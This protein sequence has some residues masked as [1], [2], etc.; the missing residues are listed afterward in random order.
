MMR[1]GVWAWLALTLLVVQA[2][3]TARGQVT[4]ADPD[5]AARAAIRD[6]VMRI[7]DTPTGLAQVEQRCP[8]LP[9]ALQTAGIRSLIIASSRER[10]DRNSL[11]GLQALLHP[12]PGAGPEVATLEPIL[13]ELRPPVA[14]TR[15]WWQRLWDWIV[16]RFTGKEPPPTDAWLSEIVRQMINARWLWISLI[17]CLL[18]AVVIA[19][20][21]V[22]VREARVRRER[23]DQPVAAPRPGAVPGPADSR[24]ALLRRAPLEQR[25][26]QLFA[27]LISRL[28]SAGRLPAD[29]SLT[30]REVVRR[31]QLDDPEQRRFIDSLARLSERQIYSGATTPPEGIEEVLARGEDLYTVGWGRP[32]G[33]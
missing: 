2:W 22:V 9:F 33:E 31:A 17:G 8:E 12:T 3:D 32:A 6:C 7:D 25:P 24:L 20:I 18:V 28:V 16:R 21:V 13:R 11:L 15:S 4:P 26:A 10:F 1:R 29:R 30:H 23:M 27:M 14:T 19:V 5:A